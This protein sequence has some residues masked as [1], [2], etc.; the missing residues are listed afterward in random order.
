MIIH[1]GRHS[2]KRGDGASRHSEP[3]RRG[4][5]FSVF[6]VE[7]GQKRRGV[8]MKIRHDSVF[9]SSVLFTIALLSLVPWSW[10]DAIEGDV[11]GRMLRGRHDVY[12]ER[13]D[14]GER[15]ATKPW[16]IAVSLR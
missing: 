14:A 3:L 10:R 7:R 5:T 13:L 1:F 11:L 8:V 16:V 9:V 2:S 12:S 15:F 6:G 4:G